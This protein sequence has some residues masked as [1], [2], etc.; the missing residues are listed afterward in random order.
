MDEQPVDPDVDR[1][2]AE[3]APP[4]AER[5]AEQPV[6]QLRQTMRDDIAV[7]TR[8]QEP[9]AVAHVRDEQVIGR[10]GPIPVRL[11]GPEEPTAVLVY[12]HGGAWMLGDIDTHDFVT[13]RLSRDTGALVASVDYRMLPEHPFP[14]PFEDSVD[15]VVWASGLRPDLPFLVGGDSA[16]GTLTAC[17]ALW[18]RDEGGP[19]ID[20]QV[21]VYPAI[22][23]DLEAPS[24]AG[25]EPGRRADLE[26]YI[27]EYAATGAA[28]GSP[29]ALPGR[30]TSL[31]GLPPAVLA[32]AGHD[33]LR[34]AEEDFAR[35]LSE[36]GV[37]VTVQLDHE[38][39]HSWID[40]APRVPAA[41][42]AF[43]RLTDT[44]SDLI[45]RAAVPA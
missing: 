19:R 31:A 35:R 42:R 29:Y 25:L 36:A 17:L 44:V 4:P 28:A 5:A 39:T 7:F 18:A 20:A 45:S 22:D 6:E 9:P 13:R 3:L 12:L 30:A 16:G 37:E 21:L 43:T 8:G 33:P 15:A 41:D 38:L 1:L 14:A 2:M 34:S 40:Y 27:S 26:F 32:I 10:H 23:D 11:Y 24:W